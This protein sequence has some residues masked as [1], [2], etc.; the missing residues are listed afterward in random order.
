M[1]SKVGCSLAGARRRPSKRA[2]EH[3][4]SQQ[5][6]AGEAVS[7][8]KKKEKRATGRNEHPP[9]VSEAPPKISSSTAEAAAGPPVKPK[10]LKEKKTVDPTRTQGSSKATTLNTKQVKEKGSQEK[11]NSDDKPKTQPKGSIDLSNGETQPQAHT[12][13]SL[14]GEKAAEVVTVQGPQGEVMLPPPKFVAPAHVGEQP[15]DL[16]ITVAQLRERV[17]GLEALTAESLGKSNALIRELN[18]YSHIRYNVERLKEWTKDLEEQVR[19]DKEGMDLEQIKKVIGEAVDRVEEEMKG[20]I[21]RVE[22]KQ[23]RVNE[24][25]EVS[26]V[27]EMKKAL[28]ERV[29]RVEEWM[30]ERVQHLETLIQSLSDT[31]KMGGRP[32][33]GLQTQMEA[34]TGS[35]VGSFSA[36]ETAL[37]RVLSSVQEVKEGQ[38]TLKHRVAEVESFQQKVLNGLYDQSRG[39]RQDF[40]SQIRSLRQLIDLQNNNWDMGAGPL[41]GWLEL[42]RELR[43]EFLGCDG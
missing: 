20:R 12:V 42:K 24:E 25:P 2:R 29:D 35:M 7:I 31:G 30:K 13:Y 4:D 32:V 33:E 8:V 15:E 40:D 18:A 9:A 17:S 36:V 19:A 28:G 26:N 39:L 1:N 22:E 41:G 10:G 38:D 23:A 27:E 43:R 34:L 16:R 21:G 3:A 11:S 5:G 6:D 14:N 37:G